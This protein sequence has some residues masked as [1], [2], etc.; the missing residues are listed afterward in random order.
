M[1]LADEVAKRKAQERADAARRANPELE[2][3]LDR[4]IAENP[5]LQE[6]FRAMSREELVRILM[7]E[8]MERAE[9]VARRNRELEPWVRQ[10]PEIVAKV[11]ERFKHLASENRA[12]AAIRAAKS[13]AVSQGPRIRP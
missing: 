10:N 9:A 1:S 2:A 8:K 13:E 7:T 6:H 12:R 11:E 4:F 3:K 5:P